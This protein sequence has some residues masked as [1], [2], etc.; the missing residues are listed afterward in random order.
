MCGG[1]IIGS[2]FI[3]SAAHCMDVLTVGNIGAIVGDHN[4][5]S[6]TDTIYA[7]VYTISAVTKHPSYVST[8]KGYDIALFKTSQE[9]IFSRGVGPA[10]LPWNYAYTS[11]VGYKVDVTGWGTTSFGGLRSPYLRKVILDMISDSSCSSKLQVPITGTQACTFTSGRD[12]C[13][14]DSGA[15]LFLRYSRMFVIGLVSYGKACYGT[16]PSV[17]TK[18]GP[19]LDWIKNNTPGELFCNKNFA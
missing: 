6:G 13:Q 16:S 4:L 1:T 15:G 5:D 12:T 8:A 10:C 11:F 7:T 2:R 19:L 14:F 9:I 18:I 3:L 17:N